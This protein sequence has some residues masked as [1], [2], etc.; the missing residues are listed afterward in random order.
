M[1]QILC[2]DLTLGYEGRAIVEGLNFSVSRGDYLVVVGENGSGKT[3]LMKTLLHLIPPMSGEIILGDGL[4]KNQIGYLPQQTPVQRDFPASVL[5]IVR[6]GLVSGS[7]R[8]FL[9]AKEKARAEKN[10]E[11]M[12]ILPLAKKT[13]RNLSGGQQQRVLLARAHCAADSMLLLDEPTAG[14]DPKA[15]EGMY[16]LI[17]S[18]HKEGMTIVM[19][20]TTSQRSFPPPPTSCTWERKFSLARGRNIWRRGSCFFLQNKPPRP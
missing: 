15:T 7:L 10:M 2:R 4:Q 12:D 5:E 9:P 3:T 19:I 13:Y 18:L 16:T 6:S 11:R 14:L 17:D 1:A 8:P 20:P